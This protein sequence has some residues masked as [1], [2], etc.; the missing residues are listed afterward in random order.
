MPVSVEIQSKND[1]TLAYP[2]GS[3]VSHPRPE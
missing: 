2:V 3:F 1:E